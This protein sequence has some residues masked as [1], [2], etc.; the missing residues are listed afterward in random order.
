MTEPNPS[1]APLVP[2]GKPETPGKP[3]HAG[4]PEV[5]P[6]DKPEEKEKKDPVREA[7]E[8]AAEQHRKAVLED[9]EKKRKEAEG[10]SE[11]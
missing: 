10:A 6:P 7:V 9:G 5:T 1:Q 8:K 11:K 4:K 2:P 3:P